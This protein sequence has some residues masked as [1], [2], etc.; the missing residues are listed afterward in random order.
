VS[1]IGKEIKDDVN[2]SISAATSLAAGAGI[3]AIGGLMLC[4]MLALLIDT[5]WFP[6]AYWAG[7]LI[8]GGVLTAVGAVMLY[9]A[10]KKFEEIKD[11]PLPE[12][13]Q[14]LQENVTWQTNPNPK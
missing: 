5:L 1:L 8:V 12:S 3:A 10:V 7:F 6:Q 14:A 4:M 2:K 9:L 11:K 13:V